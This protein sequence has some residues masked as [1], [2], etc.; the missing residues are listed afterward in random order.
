MDSR[1]APDA[2]RPRWAPPPPTLENLPLE[3]LEFVV[4]H[5]ESAKVIVGLS[6]ASQ[7]LRSR[8]MLS[9]F[10]VWVCSKLE[11]N[12]TDWEIFTDTG[13]Y[14]DVFL[15]YLGFITDLKDGVNESNWETKSGGFD[16]YEDEPEDFSLR[17]N[18]FPYAGNAKFVALA[19]ISLAPD[20][21][22][23]NRIIIWDMRRGG[24]PPR[25]KSLGHKLRR[26]LHTDVHVWGSDLVV[27]PVPVHG[28]LSREP[29]LV[30]LDLADEKIA[31]TDSVE[32]QDEDENR[33]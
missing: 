10:R 31:E 5:I 29:L 12:A 22:E 26:V 3:L 24:G 9:D 11:L 23:R 2:K 14:R 32:F 33:P 7:S 13:S 8:L 16:L 19:Q 25:V 20:S 15:K 30:I 18:F 27:L 4:Q 28:Q 6:I 17:T 1:D 21:T